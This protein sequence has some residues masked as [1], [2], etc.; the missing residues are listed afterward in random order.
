[1]E[2]F[3]EFSKNIMI[4]MA[5][6]NRKLITKICVENISKYKGL[7]SLCIFDDHSTEYDKIDIS[8]W[9]IVDS[10]NRFPTKLG[11]EDLRVQIHK[12]A[13]SLKFKYIYHIDND[14]YHDPNWL[15][16]LYELRKSHD[17]LLGLYNSKFHID[18]TLD[19]KGSYILRS[20]CPGISYF[21]E[22]SKL[23]NVPTEF[24]KRCWDYAFGDKLCPAAISNISYVEHFGADGV[25]NKDF[26]RDRACNPS[27]WLVDERIRIL[28]ILNST[29]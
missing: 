21:Y 19:D 29:R 15:I 17:G 5:T 16:R 26:D 28:N 13:A 27:S 7:A 4:A 2:S 12:V 6:Y 22:V 1:M 18:R 10:V 14:A 24:G 23:G 25:H 9:G 3:E 20:S 8:S 11:I